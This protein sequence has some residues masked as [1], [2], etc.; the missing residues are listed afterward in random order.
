MST[1]DTGTTA[2][3]AGGLG[4]RSVSVGEKFECPGSGVASLKADLA[5]RIPPGCTL[6]TVRRGD[7]AVISVILA[8]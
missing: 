3:E 1:E 5:G 7:R 6:S 2:A 8:K 4:T